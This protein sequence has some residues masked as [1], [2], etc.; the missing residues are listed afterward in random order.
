[1]ESFCFEDFRVSNKIRHSK[2]ILFKIAPI[3]NLGY[4]S[5]FL[6]ALPLPSLCVEGDFMKNSLRMLMALALL[7]FA[8]C[9]KDN[10]KSDNS[11][12]S[13]GGVNSNPGIINNNGTASATG[14]CSGLGRSY[15]TVSGGNLT[16]AAQGFLAQSMDLSKLGTIGN[17]AGTGIAFCGIVPTQGTDRGQLLIEFWDSVAIQTKVTPVRV[18][19]ITSGALS[20]QNNRIVVVFEDNYSAVQFDGSNVNNIYQGTLNY[21]NKGTKQQGVMGSFQVPLCGFFIC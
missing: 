11:I 18:D 1:M 3:A 2:R 10:K 7:G 14:T 9:D 6:V 4:L 13:G 12:R 15:G 16:A 21:Y 19:M 17:V 20:S 5:P 8:A